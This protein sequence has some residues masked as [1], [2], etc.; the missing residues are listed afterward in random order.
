MSVHLHVCNY[1]K[2]GTGVAYRL[3]WCFPQ[4]TTF[5]HNTCV[6]ICKLI[7]PDSTMILCVCICVERGGACCHNECLESG[8]CVVLDCEESALCVSN[9][10]LHAYFEFIVSGK[11]KL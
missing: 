10:M 11:Q 3:T 6:I 4:L 1:T 2:H 5:F 7:Q 8:G 9:Q